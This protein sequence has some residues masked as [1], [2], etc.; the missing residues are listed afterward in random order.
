MFIRFNKFKVEKNII[1]RNLGYLLDIFYGFVALSGPSP[2]AGAF[3][4]GYAFAS[5]GTS[6]GTRYIRI[7][8]HDVMIHDGQNRRSW[9]G[10]TKYS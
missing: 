9:I 6:R 2:R 7:L 1:A 5:H 3:N 8:C 4:G 10:H